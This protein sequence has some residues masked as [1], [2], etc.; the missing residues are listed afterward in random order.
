MAQ[1]ARP[2]SRTLLSSHVLR[3]RSGD[4]SLEV[5]IVRL[6]EAVLRS[7]EESATTAVVRIGTA[8]T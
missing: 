2:A 6:Q 7:A 1:M 3:E 4:F 8:E 5:L